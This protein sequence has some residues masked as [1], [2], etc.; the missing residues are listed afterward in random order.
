VA[1]CRNGNPVCVQG[2]TGRH[3]QAEA[4]LVGQPKGAELEYRVIAINKSG[5]GEASN[6]AMVVL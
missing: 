6:T 2:R 1:G 5:E 3:A 4:T